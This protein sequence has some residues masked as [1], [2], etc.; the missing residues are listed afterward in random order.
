MTSGQYQWTLRL[1][2]L[3]CTGAHCRLKIIEPLTELWSCMPNDHE[4]ACWYN[5][6]WS[7]SV[8]AQ[9]RGTQPW[10]TID[11]YGYNPST[12]GTLPNNAILPTLHLKIIKDQE[13]THLHCAS[14]LP[15]RSAT[16]Y[17]PIF[18]HNSSTSWIFDQTPGFS[19]SRRAS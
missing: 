11:S 9:R 8:V 5:G 12:T 6:S 3:S 19:S 18:K 14:L 13:E 4:L 1:D 2:S 10:Y 17:C 15:G 7:T 16:I